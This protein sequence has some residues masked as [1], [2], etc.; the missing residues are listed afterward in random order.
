[1]RNFQ[2][3]TLL[4]L[5]LIFLSSCNI[6]IYRNTQKYK[7]LNSR[8]VINIQEFLNQCKVEVYKEKKTNKMLN[9]KYKL[10][11]GAYRDYFSL[12][13]GKYNGL[14]ETYE[15]GKILNIIEYQNG[16]KNGKQ[17]VYYFFENDVEVIFSNYQ[18]GYKQGEESVY[19]ANLLNRKRFYTNGI[20]ERDI[21]FNEKGDT[22]DELTYIYE[23]DYHDYKINNYLEKNKLSG[24]FNGKI[25]VNSKKGVYGDSPYYYISVI[26]NEM[27]STAYCVCQANE[28]V[29]LVSTFDSNYLF[30]FNVPGFFGYKELY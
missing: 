29:Y 17:V 2:K 7:K 22:I 14:R 1:M 15:R 11:H 6:N 13:N 24:Y 26:G 25:T 20:A 10:K 9:G 5:G 18:D 3:L 4:F 23:P 19:R 27:L 28:G 12:K 16:L 21:F 30:Y 8:N